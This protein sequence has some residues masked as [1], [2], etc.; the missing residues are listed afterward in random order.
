MYSAGLA[1]PFIVT[2]LAFGRM[3]T[4]FAAIKRHYAL[5]VAAGGAI[6]IATG[7][8]ILTGDFFQLNITAQRWTSNL[9]I[10]P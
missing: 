2:A 6:L 3:T 7:V 8:L 10:N 4:A 9:G 1:V 5:I